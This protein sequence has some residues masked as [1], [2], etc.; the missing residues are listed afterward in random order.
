[1][2]RKWMFYVRVDCGNGGVDLDIRIDRSSS[3]PVYIQIK[4]RIRDMIASGL[5]LPE[6]KI[7]PERKLAESLGVNRTTVLNAY[8]ELKAEGL[9]RAVRGSGTIV[10]EHRS[11]KAQTEANFLKYRS[12]NDF[13]AMNNTNSNVIREWLESPGG[14]DHISFAVGKPPSDCIPLEMIDSAQNELIAQGGES[15]FQHCPT[16][17]DRSLRDS[18]SKWMQRRGADNCFGT[19]IMVV[20]GAQQGLDLVART[21]IHQGDVVLVEQPTYFSAVQLFRMYGANVIAIPFDPKGGLHFD[22][23]ETMIVRHRPKFI[24]VQPTFQNPTGQAWPLVQREQLIKLTE[25]YH[26]L[27]VEEDPYFELRYEGEPTPPLKALDREGLVVYVGTFSKLL[28]P[29]MRVGWVFASSEIIE[30]M[31]KWK[32]VMDLHSNHYAQAITNLIIRRG[33]LERHLAVCKELYKD[34]RNLMVCAMETYAAQELQCSIPQGGYFLWAR[35]PQAVSST[36]L[37]LHALEQNVS[38]VPGPFFSVDRGGALASHIRLSF[39]WPNSQQ[40][41]QGI[42]ILAQV[43]RRLLDNRQLRENALRQSVPLV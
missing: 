25:R 39:T 30:A 4:N 10:Q 19:E 15:L 37:L 35:L 6:Q 1:M 40:I 13:P 34:K 18:I 28:Y 12:V 42:S 11:E 27:I 8:Q 20:S 23:L 41:E 26:T 43:I 38:F 32:Q 17:G 5:L 22:Y 3:L 2:V 9:V 21:F 7:P 33:F 29:G 36:T 16:E 31:A 14:P 24:Y